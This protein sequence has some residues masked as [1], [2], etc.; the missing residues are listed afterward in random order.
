MTNDQKNDNLAKNEPSNTDELE[1]DM[2]AEDDLEEE[3]MSETDVEGK[4]VKTDYGTL[5]YRTIVNEMQD[6]YLDYAM[7]VIVARALPDVRDGLKP[8]HRRVLYSMHELGLRPSAKFRKSATVVGDVL[9]KYHPHGDI[10]VYDSMVRMAQSFSMRYRL[11]NGQ[12]NFGSM[13]G[14]SAAAMR[15]TEAKMMPIAEEMLAD[16]EKQTVDFT[17]NYDGSRF[18]PKVLPAKVPQLLL[19]GTLGIAVGMA[20]NIPP[21]NLGEIIDAAAHLIDNPDAEVE[22]LMQFV[23]GPDF[24]TGAHIYDIEEIKRAYSTGKG[25]VLMRAVAEIEEKSKGT[26][27][28]VISE[29]PY[30]VNKADL[31]LKIAQLV[32]M[33][34]IE[35][36]SDLR[37]E[38]DRES[39]VRIVIDLKSSAYP[40][41]ILNRLYELTPMQSAFHVNMLAL[42]DGIQPKVLTLKNVLDEFIKFR[43]I[44]IRRRTVFDL[45]KAKDRAHILEGLKKALDHID[46]IIKTIKQSQTKEIAHK[47]LMAE[48]TLSDKQSTAI[49]EMKLSTLSG[50]ERKKIDDELE[51]K[52]RLISKLEAILAS[53]DKIKKIIKDELQEIKSKYADKRRTKVFKQKVNEFSAEDLIPNEQVF[54]TLTNDNY[55]K[56]V[57]VSIYHSQNRGGKG[58]SGM[59][60]KEED[61]VEHF[62]MSW[63]HDEL[64]FFTDRGRVFS[65]RVYEVPSFSRQA[66]GL[67]IANLIQILPDEKVTAII[68]VNP[69]DSTQN[70]YFFM[71]TKKGIVKKTEV[72]KF[73]NIRK[74]GV[75]AI[76][77]KPNDSLKWIKSTNGLNNMIMITKQGK[78]IYFKEENVRPMGRSASGVKGISLKPGDEVIAMDIITDKENSNIFT[79]LQKGFGKRT[80]IKNFTIQTRGGI[81]IRAS[82]VTTKTGPVV[83][84]LVVD[85]DEGD[86]VIISRSGQVIRMPLK[87]VK[88]LG[89]DTQGVTLMRLNSDDTIASMTAVKKEPISDNPPVVNERINTTNDQVINK[90]TKIKKKSNEK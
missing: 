61:F 7:S 29:I 49:L 24:P 77:M 3:I 68:A 90:D 23:Q 59:T 74:T 73:S 51:E 11:V 82:K 86:V 50:L 44:V 84:V 18:E 1:R 66:K 37:D 71:G 8:V 53:V 48:F 34:K 27:R 28:I 4:E 32:K 36:V 64:L 52:K 38:S 22:D 75:I 63:T 21:H 40:K 56:R 62:F 47:K 88:K 60:T 78:A 46:E 89:R 17:P 79:I 83:G 67:A 65:T 85:N 5:K 41:K 13:D 76:K 72:E 10:A 31:I 43:Q 25:K 54:I 33:K 20:T 69:K 15:Y 35:G 6:S 30:Q 55:I 16:I 45:N 81:G 70:K 26:F 58:V 12:G 80:S 87:S 42:I 14:D 57:P 19:N 39:G 9:G 2:Q